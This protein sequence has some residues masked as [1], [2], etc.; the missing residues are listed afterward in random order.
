MYECDRHY[1]LNE[2][3]SGATCVDGRWS[4]QEKPK[5]IRGS[6][7]QVR[8]DRSVR[9][10][11][12]AVIR[13]QRRLD[14]NRTKR[15][16]RGKRKQKSYCKPVESTPWMDVTVLKKGW[17]SNSLASRGTVIQVT[18]GWGYSL[19]IGNRTAKCAAGRWKPKKP[20]CITST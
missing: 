9:E 1:T 19:N 7:P 5:C 17:M 12:E 2:G 14:V 15:R 8:W 10:K 16:K 20:E 4:P 3:P 18:C 11:R 6:H 13:R